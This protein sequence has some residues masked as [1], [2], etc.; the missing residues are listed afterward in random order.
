MIGIHTRISTGNTAPQDVGV[1]PKMRGD[2]TP[3]QGMI[4]AEVFVRKNVFGK[5]EA[6][7]EA[8]K[9]L[10]AAM[11]PGDVYKAK[12]TMPRNIVNHRRFFALIGM[13]FEHM[14]EHWHESYPSEEALRFKLTVEAGW[15]YWI[16]TSHGMVPVPKSISFAKADEADFRLVWDAVVKVIVAQFLPTLDNQEIEQQILEILN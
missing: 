16:P 3:A 14:P 5:L 1:F 12:I 8:G 4:M 9:A 15:C 10:V 13:C 7:D 2:G 6:T 11:K